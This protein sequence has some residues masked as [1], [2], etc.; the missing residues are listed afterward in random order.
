MAMVRAP[1]LA[2]RSEQ[3]YYP[4]MSSNPRLSARALLGA[5]LLIVAS[6]GAGR[7]QLVPPI[8]LPRPDTARL[9]GL[10]APDP[11]RQPTLEP[12][13]RTLLEGPIDRTEYILGPGD[14]LTLSMFG[15]RSQ[16]VTVAVAPEGTIVIPEV[17]VVRVGGLNLEQ[18]ERAA[19]TRIRR[20]FG[21]VEVNLTLSGL[22]SFKVYVVGG[23]P[24][25]GAR[26][27]T[28]VTRVSELVEP[29]DSS[30]IIHRNII[31]RRG[32]GQPQ[33]VDLASFLLTG[34]L[35]DN[36]TVREGDVLHVPPVDRLVSISG[37]VAFPGQYEFRPSE[38]LA[39]LLELA[40]GGG[41]FPADAADSIR[42]Q[43]F[44]TDPRGEVHVISRADAVGAVGQ[45]MTLAPFDA[46]F[47]PAVGQ[48]RVSTTATIGGEVARPG[49]YPIEAEV[50]TVA[51]LVEMAGGL[52]SRASLY[53]AL[54]RRRPVNLPG[55]N[56]TQLQ[57]IPPELLSPEELQ[58]LQVTTRGD[59]QVVVTDLRAVLTEGQSAYDLPLED[60]DRLF[61]PELR[62]EVVVLGAVLKP[63]IVAYAP[64][65]PIDY[66]V[67]L[68]GGYTD[69]ADEND[70]AVLKGRLGNRLNRN[71]VSA[72]DPGDRIVVPFEVPRTFLERIQTVQVV[73]TTISGLVLTIVGL[74]QLWN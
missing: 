13:G 53:D 73:A 18:A 5:L 4:I 3:V 68:A 74:N 66:Y 6:A 43:R 59:P 11:W 35:A 61:I 46:L 57:A 23:V 33:R 52:T 54:L 1:G 16:V 7:A 70:V 51:D 21:D 50:T 55:D 72:L 49:V 26:Q 67:G 36:P 44:T 20:Y 12:G 22:R 47:V 24:D 27:A 2:R 65:Q 42:L 25:P 28:A 63:G 19:A 38:T 71:D 14:L 31:V 32:N 30:G 58:I 17:G 37:R 64:G 15:F 45:G 56:D 34:D 39:E 69:R 60:G 29:A 40:N 8:A 62:E 10:P 9:G 41:P 48:Y